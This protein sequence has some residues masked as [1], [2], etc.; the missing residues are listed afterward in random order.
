MRH[1]RNSRFLSSILLSTCVHMRLT[2]LWMSTCRRHEIQITRLK[3]LALRPSGPKTKILLQYDCSLFETV[4]FILLIYIEKKCPLFILP[5][6]KILFIKKNANFFA[7]DED[8]MTSVRSSFSGHSHGAHAPEPGPL[9]VDIINGC[10][11][12]MVLM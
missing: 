7:R 11:K 1:T 4:L 12:W 6:D 5:R 8:M 2:P 3:Q 10:H 9:R